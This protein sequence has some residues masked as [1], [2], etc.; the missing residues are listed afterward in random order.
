MLKNLR[1]KN[2]LF[3]FMG[4]TFLLFTVAIVVALMS[5][6]NTRGRFNQFVDHDLSLQLAFSDMYAQGLQMGQAMRNIQLDPT[7]R[8]AYDNLNKAMSDFEGAAESARQ[9]AASDPAMVTTLE[10]I[11]ELRK[12]Q[13]A[14]Q[15]KIVA[16]VTAGDLEQAKGLLNKEE[17]PLWRDI[18]QVILDSLKAISE[19]T[20][21]TKRDVDNS[22]S[23]GITLSI[24]LGLVAVVAGLGI[25][26]AIARNLAGQICDLNRSMKELAEGEGDLTKRIA[27]EGSNELAETAQAF[28]RF[29]D[30][31]LQIERTVMS[32]AD[33]VASAAADMTRLTQHIADSSHQ[34]SEAAAT[35]AAAVEE[36]TVSISQVAE[37]A[38]V[39]KNNAEDAARLSASGESL[40]G[41]ATSEMHHIAETVLDAA[42]RIQLLRQHSE[43]ISGIANVIKEI[44]DQTNLL[45][46]NAAIEAARAGEQGRGF[47]VV[48]DEVRKLAERTGTATNEIKAMI[49]TVQNETQN[50]VSGME[51]GS[52]QV[53]SGVRTV[54]LLVEPLRTLNE[55]AAATLMHLVDLASASREQDTASTLI[56][57]QLER[58]A[59]MAEQ[60]S[61]ATD[62][63]S[64][65][66]SRMER[67][68]VTLKSSVSQFKL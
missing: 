47:A 50:A 44:A 43:Q 16:L 33:E 25:S 61:H 34:Q 62:Q 12:K 40:L 4:V 67:L 27:V 10:R 64:Q 18:K 48:A 39:A 59:Q 5:L 6:N 21:R 7:N 30:G 36:M 14:S 17:T 45:A 57:Q 66:A 23:R 49:E 42:A 35:T 63:A 20:A 31:L 29:M 3:L 60:S 13:K 68:A 58:I 32:S 38:Q 26:L 55:G 24:I 54:N 53:E 8:K 37:H 51:A 65:A 52:Q 15:E 56:A 11:T 46:L 1:V 2:Q 19:E 28:N 41:N 22:A 9:L